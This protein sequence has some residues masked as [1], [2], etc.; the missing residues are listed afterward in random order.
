MERRHQ[1]V[2]PPGRDDPLTYRRQNLDPRSHVLEERRPDKDPR[3]RLVEA[4]DL[5]V[6][7]EG[8]DLPPEPVALDQGV[9]QAEKRLARPRRRRR[10][11]DHPRARAPDRTT[12]VEEAPDAVEEPR[13]DHHLPY[14]R[15][16]ATGDDDPGQTFQILDGPDLDRLDAQAMQDLRLLLEV[17]LQ[18]EHPAPLGG[19]FVAHRPVSVA[20][21]S[22][23]SRAA[24][25]PQDPPSP[26]RPSPR[27]DPCSPPRRPSRPCSGWSP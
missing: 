5:E 17:S 18:R 19:V 6:R 7:F 9:H 3:E 23:G 13:G 24:P 14:R 16:L 2:L 12:L 1:N 26:Y 21:T 4:L 10:R 22:H 20:V 25:L 11:E 15:G 27:R 8:V